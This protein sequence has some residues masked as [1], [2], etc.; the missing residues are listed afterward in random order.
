MWRQRAC[1]R[2]YRERNPSIDDERYAAR[3][4]RDIDSLSRIYA[5]DYVLVTAEGDF[6]SKA[7]QI[8]EVTSDVLKIQP[9]EILERSVTIKS[10]LALVVG[11]FNDRL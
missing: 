10:N 1:W 7:D 4:R 8:N 2:C 6:R 11:F 9:P 3:A 5:D